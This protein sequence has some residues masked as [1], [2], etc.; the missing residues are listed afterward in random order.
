[1]ADSPQDSDRSGV[2]H[3]ALAAHNG[4]DGDDVIRIGC[5]AHAEEKTQGDYGEESDH[6]SFRPR[7]RRVK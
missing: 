2:A 5:V 3:A 4:G 1:V 7:Q 6:F